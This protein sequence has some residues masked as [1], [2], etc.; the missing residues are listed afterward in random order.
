M[1]VVASGPL[2]PESLLIIP[3]ILV[4]TSFSVWEQTFSE[5]KDEYIYT[6]NHDD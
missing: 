2:D 3:V 5:Y 4:V 1:I 6:S